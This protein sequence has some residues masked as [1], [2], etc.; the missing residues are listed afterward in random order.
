VCS[1]RERP[2]SMAESR[3]RRNRRKLDH[4]V[5]R[6]GYRRRPRDGKTQHTGAAGRRSRGSGRRRRHSG[7]GASSLWARS[8]S[9]RDPTR[10]RT[11]ARSVPNDLTNQAATQARKGAAAGACRTSVQGPSVAA[12]P[13]GLAAAYARETTGTAHPSARRA[14]MDRVGST[15]ELAYVLLIRA[16]NRLAPRNVADGPMLNAGNRYCEGRIRWTRSH[17]I[18]TH[19]DRGKRDALSP[20]APYETT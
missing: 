9:R 15:L 1:V 11:S 8:G 6:S 18:T 10:Q 4:A 13:S 17:P 14:A 5:Q 12:G 20:A 7:D 16:N 19:D 2:R 3:T